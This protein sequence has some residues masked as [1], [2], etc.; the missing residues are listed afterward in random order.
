[1][2]TK[3]YDG[4]RFQA[5]NLDEV[6]SMLNQFSK[7]AEEEVKTIAKYNILDKAVNM[8]DDAFLNISSMVEDSDKTRPFLSLAKSKIRD[9]MGETKEHDFCA[10]DL[11]LDI[12][13]LMYKRN[14]LGIPFAQIHEVKNLVTKESWNE[15]YGYWDNTDKPD[16]M[17][18]RS[19]NRRKKVWNE[20]FGK[21]FI[22][23]KAGYTKSI[24]K[25]DNIF[26][27]MIQF[28]DNDIQNW[29]QAEDKFSART[30]EKR[31]VQYTEMEMAQY[32]K[33]T[34]SEPIN[35][36]NI[37]SVFSKAKKTKQEDNPLHSIYLEKKAL[38]EELLPQTITFD[39]LKKNFNDITEISHDKKHLLEKMK[40]YVVKN[41]K[42]SLKI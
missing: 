38:I 15:E 27:Q 4:F 1:M 9:E 39:L 5:K 6:L 26:Y 17:D 2:S 3:I 8:L 33:M 25:T 42:S 37:Y 20:A 32:I 10:H 7:K 35:E 40:S 24:V 36:S 11:S 22:P 30:F 31:V 12:A 41:D 29:T 23:A 28:N 34:S 18:N 21:E 13:V 19:W 14:Y 16:D